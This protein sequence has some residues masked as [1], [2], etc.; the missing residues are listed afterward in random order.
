M[1]LPEPLIP[2]RLVSR[3]KR[4]FADIRLQSGEL[5]TAHCANSGS[6]KGL[7]A[8]NSKVL[9]SKSDNPRRKLAYT[10]ELVRVNNVW[11]C[12]NTIMPNRVVREALVNRSIP[13]LA[14][15]SEVKPEAKWQT[16]T[17]FDFLLGGETGRCYLEVKNVTLAEGELALFPDAV[18]ERGRKHLIELTKVVAAGMRGVLLFLVN[19][20]D[21][22]S[23]AP[24]REI[25]PDYAETLF[26]AQQAGVEV[27]VYRSEIE[28]PEIMVG[29][30]LGGELAE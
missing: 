13:E 19:R 1:K 16:G 28:P 11:A 10:W 17:R 2:G 3:Y 25:D 7:L 26:A 5:V 14:E 23:F 6:M 8:E 30:M 9:L 27:L 24:A 18:T 20:A 22:S 29:K 21:C 15:Y 4:F 12:V